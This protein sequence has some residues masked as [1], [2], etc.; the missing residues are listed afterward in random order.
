MRAIEISAE[1]RANLRANIPRLAGSKARGEEFSN[2][3]AWVDEQGPF[4]FVLDGANIGFF[5]QACACAYGMH[6][7]VH[8]AGRLMHVVCTWYAHGMQG[9][10]AK[11]DKVAAFSYEQVDAVLRS[12]C[13]R[14]ERVLLVLHVSH[15]DPTALGPASL[16]LVQ[17][18]VWYTHGVWCVH[19]VCGVQTVC[20]W[21]S[22]LAL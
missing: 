21:Y 14:S 6:V 17:A 13:A 11:T 4:E 8:M 19:T 18:R 22:Y 1:A 15:T 5:G 7:H 12:V 9:K 3:G 16:K 20:I 2:F 10:A